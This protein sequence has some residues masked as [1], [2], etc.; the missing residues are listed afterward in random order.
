MLFDLDLV[1]VFIEDA[2]LP[3]EHDERMVFI[4]MTVNLVLAALIVD[5]GVNPHLVGFRD[6]LRYPALLHVGGPKRKL[7]RLGFCCRF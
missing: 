5:L 3:F 7:L 4:E 2:H 1:A 6:Q